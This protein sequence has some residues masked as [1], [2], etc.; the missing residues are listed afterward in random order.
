MD[1]DRGALQVGGTY[2]VL[3]REPR[4]NADEAV[5]NDLQAR[6]VEGG[7][8]VVVAARQ[9]DALLRIGQGFLQPQERLVGFESG[10]TLRHRQ[11]SRG[12]T[13]EVASMDASFSLLTH[14]GHQFLHRLL[15][16]AVA[17]NAFYQVGD[18]IGTTLEL[19]IHLRPGLVDAVPQRDEAVI[20]RPCPAESQGNEVDSDGDNEG[21]PGQ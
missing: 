19:D 11:Q 15:M 5:G 18:E 21:L 14:L 2:Q 13:F 9:R 6:V 17:F 10:I 7:Y 16:V 20:D 3:V 12:I 8:V 1:F 4:Q